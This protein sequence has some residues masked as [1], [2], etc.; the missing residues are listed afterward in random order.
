MASAGRVSIETA[1]WADRAHGKWLWFRLGIP[2]VPELARLAWGIPHIIHLPF[3][4]RRRFLNHHHP[5]ALH[6]HGYW[7]R[8]EASPGCHPHDKPAQ[9]LLPLYLGFFSFFPFEESWLSG[10]V[11]MNTPFGGFVTGR[12]GLQV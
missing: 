1:G 10:L 9:S 2:W 6:A 7:I 12:I 3:Q 11:A 8:L 5:L 4:P